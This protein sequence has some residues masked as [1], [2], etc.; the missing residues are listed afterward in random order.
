MKRFLKKEGF[1]LITVFIISVVLTGIIGFTFISVNRQ[2]NLKNLNSGSKRAFT[3]ADAGLEFMINQIQNHHFYTLAEHLA[4]YDSQPPIINSLKSNIDFINGCSNIDPDDKNKILEA[5]NFSNYS[6]RGQ[7][8]YNFYTVDVGK[9]EIYDAS[10]KEINL[11]NNPDLGVITLNP[12]FAIELVNF[13]EKIKYINFNNDCSGCIENILKAIESDIEGSYL[14]WASYVINQIDNLISDLGGLSGGTSDC[15]T[16]NFDK[17]IVPY[18]ID[19]PV[20]DTEI[21]KIEYEGVIVRTADVVN[22]YSTENDTIPVRKIVISAVSYVFNKP[23]PKSIY[24]NSIKNSLSLVCPRVVDAEYNKYS[25]VGGSNFPQIDHKIYVN[26]LDIDITNSKIKNIG[27]SYELTAVKRGIRAEFQIPFILNESSKV[28]LFSM[29]GTTVTW[30]PEPQPDKPTF[31]PS[32]I[33]PLNYTHYILATNNQINLPSSEHIYGP[34]RSNNFINFYG[35]TNDVIISRRKITYNGIFK[36]INKEDKKEVTYY[37]DF[38][39]WDSE[40]ETYLPISPIPGPNSG[41]TLNSENKVKISKDNIKVIDADGVERSKTW[42]I[43]LNANGIYDNNDKIFLYY[44]NEDLPLT[45]PNATDSLINQAKQEIYNSTSGTPYNVSVPNNGYV[46]VDLQNDVLKYRINGKGNWVSLPIS[47]NPG[48]VMY[49]DGEVY[50]KGGGFLDGKLTIY[51]TGDV[52]FEGGPVRYKDSP[53]SNNDQDYPNDTTDI[54]MLGIITPGKV[55]MNNNS[56]NSMKVDVNIITGSGIVSNKNHPNKI[57]IQGSMTFYDTYTG[58]YRYE[59]LNFDYNLFVTRPPMFPMLNMPCPTPSVLI[60]PTYGVT[61][62]PL[63]PTFKWKPSFG[64]PPITYTLQISTDENFS[65]IIYNQNVGNNTTYTLNFDL[66]LDTTYYWRVKA[67]NNVCDDYSATFYFKTQKDPDDEITEK[68]ISD[69]PIYGQ[70]VECYFSRR[71][72]REMANP[73]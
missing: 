22:I 54:D 44:T 2:L 61:G 56:S 65:N 29:P 26:A 24:Y 16:E 18:D 39:N 69:M 72:W 1:A 43:D 8:F 33:Y 73:P 4:F 28:R 17:I 67:S 41:I 63:K 23:V 7:Y 12:N 35:E 30:F 5:I 48:T 40:S 11:N 21:E 55:Y 62:V 52:H 60:S 10:G 47:S 20:T 13:S 38:S 51:A 70:V 32:Q 59:L 19:Y 66:N 42:F 53:K 68:I 9:R 27:L 6:S 49:I 58:E 31:P 14:I 36:F 3:V 46:E 15:P 57:K 34:V 45:D 37:V 71:L 64:A 50:F 25:L